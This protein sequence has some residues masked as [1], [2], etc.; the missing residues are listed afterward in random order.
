MT[1][2][3]YIEALAEAMHEAMNHE[4]KAASRLTFEGE[5]SAP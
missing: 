5:E 4:F 3:Q 2:Q 1:E